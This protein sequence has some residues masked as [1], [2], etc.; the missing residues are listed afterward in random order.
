MYKKIILSN[1]SKWSVF[2]NG[3]EKKKT[4]TFCFV[5]S[6]FKWLRL[7]AGNRYLQCDGLAEVGALD[8][9]GRLTIGR[10]VG[11]G[12]MRKIFKTE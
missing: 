5:L 10:N 6:G 8:E 4:D 9:V 1:K 12:R 2:P 11:V 3:T 7:V